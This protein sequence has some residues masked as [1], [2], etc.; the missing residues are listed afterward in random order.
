MVKWPDPYRSFGRKPTA[1]LAG[2]LCSSGL[3]IVDHT[4]PVRA[5]GSKVQRAGTTGTGHSNPARL[6]LVF[7]RGHCRAVAARMV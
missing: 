2:F 1:E 4:H 3:L 5:G 6:A 7:Y